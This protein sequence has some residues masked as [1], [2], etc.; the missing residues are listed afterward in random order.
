ML[1]AKPQ[2]YSNIPTRLMQEAST[3][4]PTPSQTIAACLWQALAGTS[5]LATSPLMS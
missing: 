3:L 4:S 1:G 5:I 2:T